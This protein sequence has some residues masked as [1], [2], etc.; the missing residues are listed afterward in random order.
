M[1]KL[2]ES[3]VLSAL[4]TLKQR[5]TYRHFFKHERVRNMFPLVQ[6]STGEVVSWCSNDYL[7]LSHDKRICNPAIKAI[8]NFGVGSGGTRNISGNTALTVEVERKIA[9]FHNK[10]AGLVFNSGYSANQGSLQAISRVLPN[11][12]FLS[13]VENH[14]SMIRGL[15][16]TEK[17]LF[18]HNSVEHLESLLHGIPN[19]LPKIICFESV[20]SMSGTIAPIQEYAKLAKQHNAL[21]YC[22]EIHAVGMYGQDGQG[23]CNAMGIEQDID[24][25]QAGFGK[26]FG[27]QGGYIVASL[28]W[29]DAIRHLADPFIFTTSNSIPCMAGVEA[30]I[31]LMPQLT[32]RRA[33][34]FQAVN[35]TRHALKAQNI[36]CVDGGST[37]IIA[38][39]VPG[40][41]RCQLVTNALL[42]QGIYVQP[43]QSPTVRHGNERLRITP[44]HLHS[45]KNIETLAASLSNA[46]TLLRGYETG[47]G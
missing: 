3:A 37:H 8:Q 34:C 43:I 42:Q 5:G 15:D 14:N 41:A 10:D 18:N 28:K 7:N 1:K 22:D 23:K 38:V 36:H 13:D 40:A 35:S 45:E 12:V 25:I 21:T 11:A 9:Q 16:N 27:C 30:A 26:A 17:L 6:G 24:F 2:Y 44:T 20:Y 46:M 47:G 19:H 33:A 29:I 39:G 31:D 32:K 4:H